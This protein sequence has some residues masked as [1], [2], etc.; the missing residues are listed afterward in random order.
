MRYMDSYLTW[1]SMRLKKK[2]GWNKCKKC[3][4]IFPM[5]HC[6][7]YYNAKNKSL[8]DVKKIPY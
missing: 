6:N 3:M 5:Q 8:H 7:A 1:V 2:K 4:L